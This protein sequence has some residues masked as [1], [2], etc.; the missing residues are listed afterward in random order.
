[1][2]KLCSYNIRGLNKKPK[3]AYVR[4]F[5]VDNHITFVG[6]IETTVKQHKVAKISRAV[7]RN[8]E[9]AFNYDFHYNGSIWVGWDPKVWS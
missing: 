3:Q 2:I 7:S 5:L 8:W 1:M 9:W 6:L 4:N